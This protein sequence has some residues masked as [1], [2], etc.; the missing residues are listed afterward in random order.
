MFWELDQNGAGMENE[1]LNTADITVT[2]GNTDRALAL[3]EI[4]PFRIVVIGDFT[5][6][7][8]KIDFSQSSYLIDIDKNNFSQ[9]MDK[10]S[11][12]LNIIVPNYIGDKSTEFILNLSFKDIKDFRPEGICQQIPVLFNLIKIRRLTEQL[13]DDK[14]TIQQYRLQLSSSG[15]DNNLLPVMEQFLSEIKSLPPK[16]KDS[17]LLSS[18]DNL[19]KSDDKIS[20]ILDIV[21]TTT[22][23]LET[24]KSIPPDTFSKV[25]E[26]LV[27][28]EQPSEK[29]DKAKLRL[30]IKEVEQKL[31]QQINTILHNS[32]FQQLESKWRGLKFLVD[33]M[34]FRKNL[35]LQIL[36]V[37]KDQL[38]EAIYHQL[39]LPEYNE[40]SAIPLSLIIGD[41]DFDKTAGDLEIL[42]NITHMASAIQVPFITNIGPDFFGIKKGS[43]LAN[44]PDFRIFFK[45][46]DYFNWIAYRDRAEAK[47]LALITTSFI[48]R[49][50]YG[51]GGISV[52][53]FPFQ[54]TTLTE[55]DFLWGKSAYAYAAVIARSF[56]SDGWPIKFTGLETGG[57]IENLPIWKYPAPGGKDIRIPLNNLMR[58]SKQVELTEQGIGLLSCMINSNIA[59]VFS[60][61]TFYRAPMFDNPE[62]TKE[63]IIHSS[64]AYQFF[65]SR[66]AH[67]IR[68]LK[69]QI[70]P[71]MTLEQIQ[72]IVSSKLRGIISTQE[73]KAGEDSV[74]LEI[75][76]S[77]DNPDKYYIAM[78]IIPPFRILGYRP[79]LLIGFEVQR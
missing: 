46:P 3:T 76:D 9:V 5:P 71:G 59:F 49:H 11:P 43:E 51:S 48:L 74:Y 73:M 28:K 55:S 45:Q 63:A 10:I 31:E 18:L 70:T 68:I 20:S 53:D 6:Q 61:P 30:L 65:S 62:K 67:Y 8:D 1:K 2:F 36:S 64:L 4:L 34:D 15:L 57:K 66:M 69:K 23:S 60:I 27:Q 79:S 21:E 72:K 56:V 78:R 39:M 26:I 50:P 16:V 19:N 24:E 40:I 25:V 47:Y 38:A 58:E 7:G 52:K 14:I 33:Q 12:G 54:E 37:S 17:Q 35:V 75:S 29:I 77:N 41:Y 22:G 13:I 32:Q 44:I 42:Q